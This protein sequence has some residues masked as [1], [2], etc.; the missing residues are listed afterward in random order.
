MRVAWVTSSRS[1]LLEPFFLPAQRAAGSRLTRSAPT[2]AA[3]RRWRDCVCR[4]S[5]YELPAQ[6][7][8]AGGGYKY[9]WQSTDEDWNAPFVES[10]GVGGRVVVALGKFDAMH[11]GHRALALAA[12]E[13]D[14]Q[15]WLLSFSGMSEVLG[16]APR[17]PLVADCDRPR[18]LASWG[19]LCTQVAG[20][21]V[22][23]AAGFVPQQRSI[24]FSEIRTMPP[25]E[26]VALLADSLKV[27]GVV[28]GENYRF[29]FKA[30]GDTE[31][32]LRLGEQHGLDVKIVQLVGAG[33]AGM[34]EQ[35]SSSQIRDALRE[36]GERNLR[37]VAQALGRCYRVVAELGAGD[38]AIKSHKLRLGAAC[39]LN[40]LPSEGC[41]SCRVGVCALLDHRV[42]TSYDEAR[43]AWENGVKVV[44]DNDGITLPCEEGRW[45]EEITGAPFQTLRIIVDF[46]GISAEGNAGESKGT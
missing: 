24:P 12:A 7:A 21:S 14:G 39:F 23:V 27:S 22:E 36:G 46:V 37:K 4:A 44:I 26:F 42:E 30:A 25:A 20:S 40:Q 45:C 43:G 11:R 15:P 18:V 38:V 32:L 10:D 29:G 28:A 6:G 3:R 17:K 2:A 34:P 1:T 5:S 41:Y 19:P 31:Q 33:E 13:M 8:R 9:V 35:V 16:W